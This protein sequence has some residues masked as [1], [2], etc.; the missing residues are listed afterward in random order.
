[1]W[2]G[3]GAGVWDGAGPAFG[4]QVRASRLAAGL[5]QEALAERAGL[6]ARTL[7]RLEAGAGRPY[8]ATAEAL[9]TA[10][11]LPAG[12]RDSLLA[13]AQPAPRRRAHDAH[14]G[15]AQGRPP[16]RRGATQQPRGRPLPIPPDT[17]F[18]REREAAALLDLL[19]RPDV[20]LVTLTGPGGVGKTRL[21]LHVAA[22]SRRPCRAGVCFVA[23]APLGDPAHVLP[24]VAEALGIRAA[25]GQG[26]RDP[27]GA[28]AACPGWSIL[29]A[30]AGQRR[31]LAGRSPL[32]VPDP[33]YRRAARRNRSGSGRGGAPGGLP[34]AQD[35]GH[36]QGSA[37]GAGGA[38]LPRG[39]PGPTAGGSRER[40]RSRRGARSGP[41]RRT[42][43]A[44]APGL[45][46]HP[47]RRPRRGG[48]VPAP[49]RAAPGDGA[50]GGAHAWGCSPRQGSWIA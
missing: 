37:P 22:A 44:G 28:I 27:L 40:R 45:L 7:Q 30:G 3:D 2:V 18:G 10:L 20:R 5:T 49:G 31:A 36:Q 25:P 42:G 21:A 11:G 12:P 46:P 32:R 13:T 48:A 14:D 34:G 16:P 6:S 4:A 1:M 43:P 9:A 35:P 29:A 17:L 8:R 50:G 15:A 33:G 19:R 23:L 47:A 41:V 24:A 39:P 38:G 26:D